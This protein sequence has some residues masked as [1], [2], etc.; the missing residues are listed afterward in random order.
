MLYLIAAHLFSKRTFHLAPC[1]H[2][3]D[4]QYNV[5]VLIT[6]YFSLCFVKYALHGM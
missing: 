6:L 3:T 2:I 5:A 4:S 1:S